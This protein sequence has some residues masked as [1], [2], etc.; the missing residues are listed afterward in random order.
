[1]MI[2][3]ACFD[4]AKEPLAIDPL[5]VQDL[6]RP[7][8]VSRP[9]DLNQDRGLKAEQGSSTRQQASIAGSD[10]HLFVFA[11]ASL[12]PGQPAS[13]VV[14]H[15]LLPRGQ[16]GREAAAAAA[17]TAATAAFSAVY[18]VVAA[19]AVER[20]QQW[21]RRAHLAAQGWR[22]AAAAAQQARTRAWAWAWAWAE[23]RGDG[24]GRGGGRRAVVALAWWE[25]GQDG[26]R[27]HVAH[28]RHGIEAAAGLQRPAGR[29][30][31]PIDRPTYVGLVHVSMDSAFNNAIQ[32]ESPL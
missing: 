13:H 30:F 17:A 7:P 27:D 4:Q 15:A 16:R 25:G 3:P 8:A 28:V 32:L 24:D 5:Q 20:R 21:R 11:A 6:N 12:A 9:S 29:E 19:A 31:A 18:T 14:L 22:A 23:A 26:G 1:M 10:I 2:L